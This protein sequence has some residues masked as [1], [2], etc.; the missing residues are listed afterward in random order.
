MR[1]QDLVSICIPVYNGKLFLHDCIKSVSTQVYTNLEVLVSDDG[2]VDG[3]LQFFEKVYREL[4]I[5]FPLTT[6]ANK[7][8]G[9][10]KN[11]NFLAAKASGV[12]I[13][14]LF[15]DDFIDPNFILKHV[16]SF[17]DKSKTSF[18]FSNRSILNSSKNNLCKS[19]EI[20]CSDLSLKWSKVHSLQSGKVMLEDP[21]LLIPPYNKVGEP[22][23][24]LICKEKFIE[25]GGFDETL[26]HL[27]DLDLWYRLMCIGDVAF[28]NETLSTFRVHE[29]QATFLNIEA[30]H[31]DKE[32]LLIFRAFIENKYFKNL[33][34]SFKV[35]VID[36]I[37]RIINGDKI[38]KADFENK[39]SK[40]ENKISK[41]KIDI[42]NLNQIISRKQSRIK[43]ME[44]TFVWRFRRWYMKIYY[45]YFYLQ[46]FFNK[47]LILEDN[48]N[49]KP[50]EFDRFNELVFP[51][52]KKCR[53]SIIIPFYGN[54]KETYLCL[55]SIRENIK[56][57]NYEI[58]L[59]D[60][61][62]LSNEDL[63][64]SLKNIVLIV[65]NDNLGFL[66]SCNK[67]ALNAKGE[68][69]IFLNNDTQV[70]PDWLSSIEQTF[71]KQKNVG[72]VG[73]KLIYPDGRLQEAGGIIWRDGSGCN[74]GKY[75]S[76]IQSEFCYMRD[77]DYCSG[78][79]LATPRDTF[80]KL[81]SFDERFSPAYYEDTDYCFQVR[82]N[83][84]RVIYQPESV[85]IH[86]E[87]LSCGRDINTGVKAQQ[88]KNQTIF[89]K[90]WQKQLLE[91]NEPEAKFSEKYKSANKH[92]DK[93]IVLIIDS[94]AP[95]YDKESGS[96]RIFS[97]IKIFIGLKYHVIFFPDNYFGEQ[98][99]TKTLQQLGVEVICKE[100]CA[101]NSSPIKEL[102]KRL[103]IINISW[104]CRPQLFKKYYRYF[105]SQKSLFLIYDTV[106]LHFLRL[107]R[108]WE[109][110][111]KSNKVLEKKWKKY[112]KLEK[113]CSRNAHLTI[114]VTEDECGI[115][116]EWGA[117][118][119]IIPN[120][121]DAVDDHS[122]NFEDRSGILFIGSYLHPPNVDAV[123]WLCEEI[124][125]II[126]EFDRKITL[127]LLGSNPTNEVLNLRNENVI[128]PGY[129]QNVE[130]YFGSSRVF[131][132]PLRYG[133][134]MKGKVGQSLAFGLPVVT[135][136]I[137][138]EGM[139]LVNG[140]N[141]LIADNCE[142]ISKSLL[143][144]YNDQEKWCKFSNEAISH[145]EAFSPQK[146][147][148]KLFNIVNTK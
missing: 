72:A 133:A 2:S 25:T 111:E 70:H 122:L 54:L 46:Q 49:L 65:N 57:S 38:S 92:G 141:V 32:V 106:D 69:L 102:K 105:I 143:S 123:M 29:K 87:G 33:S 19:I 148:K 136:K 85:V 28:I 66:R 15:Q 118:S 104:I 8:L 83:G 50:F 7:G 31:N 134:G 132:A 20:G 22:S 36:E 27:L 98:P 125:P 71:D 51:T 55:L 47:E 80:L 109:L 93:K 79:S 81:G 114:T 58:I 37:I 100:Y 121:H 103:P 137:G 129:V 113:K 90:K 1:S 76:P 91:H 78:A 68:I 108:Q 145:I 59:V 126:W 21:F 135:T 4:E 48:Q 97:I 89:K 44:S 138:A 124:M 11:C 99:Y 63:I 86:Y 127:T 16:E 61:N 62:S 115:V 3:S 30:G 128:V 6:F 74:Y 17:G 117:N 64:R 23:N 110:E 75:N 24:V 88:K 73:S 140:K 5:P 112:L 39:I 95:C 43:F 146:I 94:Y 12:F 52:F 142:S 14:F 34:Q 45:F 53:F 10:S 82:E 139:G 120:I 101:V 41:L 84:Y 56:T 116:K 96:N 13:K 131:V 130:P 9:I 107:K 18:S 42:E 119:D 26:V 40:L 144:I 147:S 67:G 60:D 77:V 35:R